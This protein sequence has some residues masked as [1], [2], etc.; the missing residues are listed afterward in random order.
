MPATCWASRTNCRPSGKRTKKPRVNRP[1]LTIP[2]GSEAATTS[3]RRTSASTAACSGI[4][5]TGP[6]GLLYTGQPKQAEIIRTATLAQP[7]RHRNENHYRVQQPVSGPRGPLLSDRTRRHCRF[8]VEQAPQQSRQYQH[9]DTDAG[10]KVILARELKFR[11]AFDLEVVGVVHAAV[12]DHEAR[13]HRPV[14]RLCNEPVAQL[15]IGSVH[16]SIQPDVGSRL[17]SAVV[18]AGL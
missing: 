9:P 16:N 11:G 15:V 10:Q 8:R 13:R 4:S 3:S 6:R 5:R 17:N 2:G 14:Q 18:P 1:M 12:R 7:A